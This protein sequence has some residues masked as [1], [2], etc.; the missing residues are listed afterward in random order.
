MGD[1]LDT[2]S[3]NGELTHDRC[4]N[5]SV[6]ALLP[7]SSQPERSHQECADHSQHDGSRPVEWLLEA[8]RRRRARPLGWAAVLAVTMDGTDAPRKQNG[9]R[10]SGTPDVEVSEPHLLSMRRSTA[11]VVLNRQ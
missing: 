2:R 8:V 3:R 9:Y 1:S 7:Q 5:T 11:F 4:V 10:D 6:L